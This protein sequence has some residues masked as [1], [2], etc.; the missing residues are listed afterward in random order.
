[1]TRDVNEMILFR[2]NSNTQIR[3]PVLQ[4]VYGDFIA[5]YDARGKHNCVALLQKYVGIV[6]IHNARQ[7]GAGFGLASGAQVQDFVSR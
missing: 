1:M 2:N 7:S 4:F 6:A 3:K 5:W